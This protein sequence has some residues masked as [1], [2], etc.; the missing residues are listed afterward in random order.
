[1]SHQKSTTSGLNDGESR[2]SLRGGR[3]APMNAPGAPDA[4]GPTFVE[5]PDSGCPAATPDPE[6]QR[7]SA[8]KL[9]ILY[10]RSK[11]EIDAL[12]DGDRKA[13]IRGDLLR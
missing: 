7:R 2:Y 5:S 11:S 8:D 6:R 4:S 10:C 3:S 9:F 13:T 1:M 12:H